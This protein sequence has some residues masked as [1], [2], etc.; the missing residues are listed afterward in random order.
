MSQPWEKEFN[1]QFEKRKGVIYYKESGIPISNKDYKKLFSQAQNNWRENAGYWNSPANKNKG[2][3]P[4]HWWK[5]PWII[6][7][8]LKTDV[9]DPNNPNKYLNVEQL[10]NL[11]K[12]RRIEELEIGISQAK[13]NKWNREEKQRV[14]AEKAKSL[15][16]IKPGSTKSDV[17]KIE[18]KVGND[19]QSSIKVKDGDLLSDASNIIKK[20]KVNKEPMPLSWD[21]R[22]VSAQKTNFRNRTQEQKRWLDIER[23]YGAMDPSVKDKLANRPITQL[24]LEAW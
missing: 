21:D 22:V 4:K 7:K 2:V 5:S 19:A 1:S 17:E 13:M 6:N 16:Q 10:R 24:E 11:E 18:S 3:N 15:L 14:E 23:A 12:E 8:M 20:K 9:L